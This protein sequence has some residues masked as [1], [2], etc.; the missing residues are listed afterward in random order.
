MGTDRP[1]ISLKQRNF[2]GENANRSLLGLFFQETRHRTASYGRTD[3]GNFFHRNR[4]ESFRDNTLTA[5]VNFDRLNIIEKKK[6]SIIP[7]VDNNEIPNKRLFSQFYCN[8]II[9]AKRKLN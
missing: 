7:N 1:D 4:R 8:Q 2:W 9:N 3:L 5:I 6:V